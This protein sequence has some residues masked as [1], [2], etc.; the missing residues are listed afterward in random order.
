M[1]HAVGTRAGVAHLEP[2]SHVLLAQPLVGRLRG[3]QQLLECMIVRVVDHL[4]DGMD[5][6]RVGYGHGRGSDCHLGA[7]ISSIR[8]GGS[9]RISARGRNHASSGIRVTSW[10]RGEHS[11]CLRNRA[12]ELA[13]DRLDLGVAVEFLEGRARRVRTES[14]LHVF[15]GWTGPKE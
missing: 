11:I 8:S 2:I 1:K 5:Q 6:M 14:R 9:S 7:W 15:C 12:I 3:R 4:G 10:Q 13:E